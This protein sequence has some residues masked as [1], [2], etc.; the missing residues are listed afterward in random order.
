MGSCRLKVNAVGIMYV[1]EKLPP[2]ITCAGGTV[3]NGKCFYPKGTTRKQTKKY[4][5]A[6]Q[7]PPPQIVCRGGKV[8]RGQCICPKD[9]KRK[10]VQKNTYVCERSQPQQSA[11]STQ[12]TPEIKIDPK[13]LK[14]FKGC[15]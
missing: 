6:C 5:Y 13:V 2:K 12:T 10:Q 1:C 9:T 4:S 8:S 11:P 15:R 14:Q 3:R 7:K